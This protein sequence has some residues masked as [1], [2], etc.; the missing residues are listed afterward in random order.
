MSAQSLGAGKRMPAAVKVAFAACGAWL[1][2]NEFRVVAL[3]HHSFGLVG[4]RWAHDVALLVATGLC[5]SRVAVR[6]PERKAWLLVGLGMLAWTFGEVY[7]TAVLWTDPNP[8]IPSPADGGYLLFPPLCLVGL[9]LLLR[10]RA[11]ALPGALWADGLTTGLSVGALVTALVLQNVLSHQSGGTLAV[12]TSLAYPLMDLILLSAVLGALARMGWRADRLWMLLAAGILMFWIADTLYLVATA[13]GTAQIDAWSDTGWWGGFFVLAAAAWCPDSAPLRRK[14]EQSTRLIAIPL[15]FGSVGLGTLVYGCLV[16]L[17]PLAVALAA[18][19]LLGVMVRLMLTFGENVVMLRR[20]RGEALTDALTGV[21]N[22]RALTHALERF[23]ASD[24][25]PD[26]LLALFDLDGF[27]AYNDRFG[28]PAGDAL[29]IRL[30]GQ[31]KAELSPHGEVFRLGGDEFCALVSED[32]LPGATWLEKAAGVLSESGD[33]FEIGCSYGAIRLPLDAQSVTEALELVDRSMYA[34]KQDGR[35]SAA[36]QVHDALISAMTAT[37]HG[38]DGHG[39]AVAEL[40][41]LTAAMLGMVTA[42]VLE[43]RQAAELHD[44]G[45]VAVPEEILTKPGP[46]TE[47]EWAFIREHPSVGERIIAAAP[48][49][50]SVARLVRHSHERWDGRGYPDGLAGEQIPVGA[51]I[52]AVADAFETMTRAQSYRA[53]LTVEDATAELKRCAGTQFDEVVV[54]AFLAAMADRGPQAVPSE[55]APVLAVPRWA[56][57]PAL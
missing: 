36:R 28:H 40:A 18:A 2:V 10:R 16:K 49:L 5:L 6:G 56:G 44:I 47:T 39:A 17:T 50:R 46:L 9:I 51:R 33:G 57:A 19:S 37:K 15:L 35:A 23:F 3:D 1:V 21:G 26:R 27:K 34:H 38:L 53:A 13:A 11:G 42:E 12:A 31:L 24:E 25:R 55:A 29:L 4:S 41:S 30:A 7:Y 45:M 54:G 20:S 52:I 32:H 14:P 43:V 8:P 48:A 22:R